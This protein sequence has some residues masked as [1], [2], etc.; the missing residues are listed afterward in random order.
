VIGAGL[1]E[2]Y[3]LAQT[4]HSGLANVGTRAFVGAFS[5]NLETHAANLLWGLS[6]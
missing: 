1:V 3:D 4:G 2:I 6:D 5:S